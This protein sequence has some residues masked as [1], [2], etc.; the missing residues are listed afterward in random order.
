MQIVGIIS[1]CAPV[2]EMV[3]FCACSWSRV[4]PSLP[5]CF[6]CADGTWW[7]AIQSM[8][9]CRA[10]EHIIFFWNTIQGCC[11]FQLKVKPCC[12]WCVVLS[13]PSHIRASDAQLVCSRWATLHI[14]GMRKT[15]VLCRN[16]AVIL[17]FRPV[18][19]KQSFDKAPWGLRCSSAQDIMSWGV[20]G[21]VWFNVFAKNQQIQ[22]PERSC[23]MTWKW[24]NEASTLWKVAIWLRCDSSVQLNAIDIC[25]Y[26][27]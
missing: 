11:I 22:R 26:T 25:V 20:P 27:I 15:D 6:H 13:T 19:S 16:P 12:S 1:C 18:R 24:W 21:V 5:S 14:H 10:V 7:N 23:E 4:A 3:Q 8:L 17:C 9:A 2:Q